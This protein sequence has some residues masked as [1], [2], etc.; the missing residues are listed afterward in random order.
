MIVPLIGTGVVA[1]K[2]NV[3]STADF[4]DIRSLEEM[5]NETKVTCVKM[6]P[7]LTAAL[8]NVSADVSTVMPTPPAVTDPIVKPEIVTVNAAEAGM[9]APAVVMT[10]D[11]AVVA[12]HAPVRLAILLLPDKTVGVVVAKKAEG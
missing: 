6:P 4:P 1:E 7:L 5:E 2:P 3:I 11:V 8:G 10:S 12:L 9:V